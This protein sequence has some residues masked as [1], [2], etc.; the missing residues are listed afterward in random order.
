MMKTTK[1][2]AGQRLKEGVRARMKMSGSIRQNEH[3]GRRL[4][5]SR[6]SPPRLAWPDGTVCPGLDPHQSGPGAFSLVGP[7]IPFCAVPTHVFSQSACTSYIIP[8]ERKS[9]MAAARR[10]PHE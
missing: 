4:I 9:R 8:L 7:R 6:Q 5:A 2:V 1:L 10:N 3:K